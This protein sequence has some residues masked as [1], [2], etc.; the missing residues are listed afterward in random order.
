MG[1]PGDTSVGVIKRLDQIVRI[2]PSKVLINI[3]S[4]DLVLFKSHPDEIV[5]NI[6]NIVNYLSTYVFD[7]KIYVTLV[8]PVLK[9]DVI[10]NHLYIQN[11]TNDRIE[12]IN[13][14]LKK[15]NLELVD[16]HRLWLNGSLNK[17]YS[18]DG[19][20]LNEVGYRVYIESI[21]QALK[22]D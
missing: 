15:T 1:I 18:T 4:N 20:H 12:A 17:A 21:K 9:D 6:K 10:S 13:E 19:I 8:T 7:V 5:E 2:Q 16:T 3:G 11:R 14:S 22:I